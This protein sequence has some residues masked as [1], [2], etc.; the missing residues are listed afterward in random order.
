MVEWVKRQLIEQIE[1]EAILHEYYHYHIAIDRVSLTQTGVVTFATAIR[2]NVRELDFESIGGPACSAIPLVTAALVGS[3]KRRGFFVCKGLGG[4]PLTIEGPIY[5][6]DRVVLV[7]GVTN[8]GESVLQTIKAIKGYHCQ[9]V[10]ILTI[11]DMER[12]AAELLN[13]YDFVPL[14]KISEINTNRNAIT[15]C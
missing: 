8:T 7:T 5:Q 14:L 9:I 1:R 3:P 6:G 4:S 10:R 13:E 15:G 11:I 12:G 2:E